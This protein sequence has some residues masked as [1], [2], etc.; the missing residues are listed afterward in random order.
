M[1]VN[2]ADGLPRPSPLS[3][4]GKLES[5]LQ[6]SKISKWYLTDVFVMRTHIQKLTAQFRKKVKKDYKVT[7]QLFFA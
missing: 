5:S 4:S 7:T 1:I 6:V 3:T 2:L